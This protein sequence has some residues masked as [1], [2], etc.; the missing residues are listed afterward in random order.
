MDNVIQVTLSHTNW[1]I[2][3]K[4]FLQVVIIVY[5][6]IWAWR[7]IIGTQA[8]RLVKGVLVLVI[9][10]IASY[11][12]GFTLITSALQHIIPVAVM[13]AVIIFQPEIRRGLGYL[14][15]MQTF[16]IDFSLPDTAKAE[17]T[18]DINQIITAVKELSR[19]KVGALLVIE[20]LEGE[21]DY[22]SPGTTINADISSNLLLTIFFPKSPLHDGAVVIRDT[23]I[24][25]AGVILP[26]TDNA[27][28]SQKYGTRHRA[29]IGLSEL[30]DGLCIVVSEETGAVSAASRGMLARYT[31]PDELMEPISYLYQGQTQASSPSMISS[32]INLWPWL[33][34]STTSGASPLAPVEPI[35]TA[36]SDP[37]TTAGANTTSAMESVS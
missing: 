2:L 32:L 26:M 4:N 9:V 7:R 8:E 15:R 11:F 18:H 14:G 17:R 5:G 28:L 35:Q 33:K 34:K 30:Y 37:S 23:K 12:A 16:R 13:A 31:D 27:K 10:A 20:P 6:L 3:C 1:L 25:A 22:L 24:V 36:K 19:S 21:R 29:A